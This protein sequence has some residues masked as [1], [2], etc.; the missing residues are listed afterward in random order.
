MFIKRFLLIIG[1]IVISLILV[2]VGFRFLVNGNMIDDYPNPNFEASIHQYSSNYQLVYE[3]KPSFSSENGL[4]STNKFGVRDYEYTLVKPPGIKRIAVIGDSVAFGYIKGTS[5]LPI[6]ETFSK[7]L[8][9]K[10]NTIFP[11]QYEVLNFSVTGYNAAQEEIVLKEKVLQFDPDVVIVVYVPNDDTYTD[12]LGEMAKQM[13]PYG[14]GSKLHSKL[15]AYLLYKYEQNRASHW[16]SMDQVWNL[17]EQLTN[18][19]KREGF[20]VILVISPKQTDFEKEN[21]EKYNLV[22]QNVAAHNF[23]VVDLK[24]AWL[25]LTPEERK[26][27][28]TDSLHYSTAGMQAVADTLFE[29]FH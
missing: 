26:T 22:R 7:L 27:L 17:F 2:E 18:L 29:H 15:I 8:E 28:Y 11:E 9:I 4:I 1:S 25:G 12:G 10:L 21:D 19:S 5:I 3:L 13:S 16:K 23:V 24:E 20:E 6:E 14:I